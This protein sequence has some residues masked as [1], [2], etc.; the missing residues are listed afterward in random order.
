MKNIN[1]LIADHKNLI[2]FEA[3]KYASHLPLHVVQAE[4][5]KLA[6]QAAKDFDE[7]AG[8]KF[9]TYLTNS[10]KKLSRMS[11]TYGATVRIPED[12]QYKLNKLNKLEQDMSDMLG[13]PVSVSELSEATGWPIALV[14]NLL[15]NRK[16]EVNINSLTS[17]PIFVD[18][19]NDEWVHFVYHDLADRDKVIF[20]HKTGF[21][22][23]P[24]LENAE[25]AKK[26]DMTP[27][28]VSNR[29]K[30][31]GEQIAEGWKD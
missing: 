4:A 14:S 10:L 16:R 6:H 20:E 13:R 9:S 11:T 25:I 27:A 3:S 5:Y 18:N 26:L 17:T 7:K 2:E 12:K 21:G 19:N 31:I 28:N 1:Q 15:Q 30:F 22:G 8:I 24:V 23:R 29:L